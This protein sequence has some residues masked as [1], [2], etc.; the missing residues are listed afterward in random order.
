MLETQKTLLCSLARSLFPNFLMRGYIHNVVSA[1]SEVVQNYVEINNVNS[2]LPN[3]VNFN[4]GIHNVDL[5]LPNV[6][7]PHQP[8]NNVER[9][10]K[11]LLDCFSV[12][13]ATF[14][15]VS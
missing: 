15:K 6:A 9:T 14:L 1:L 2:T 5:M 13:C 12:K 8:K 4:V 11:C 3:V 10:L 7:T